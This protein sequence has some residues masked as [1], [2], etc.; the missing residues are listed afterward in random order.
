MKSITKLTTCHSHIVRFRIPDYVMGVMHWERDYTFAFTLSIFQS[1][2]I[3]ASNKIPIILPT[4]G[5]TLRHG[6]SVIIRPI[7]NYKG[8]AFNMPGYFSQYLNWAKTRY[9]YLETHEPDYVLV[10]EAILERI[11]K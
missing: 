10:K 1:I 8:A 2:I 11:A 3:E 4:K 9:V 6:N 5:A 7:N